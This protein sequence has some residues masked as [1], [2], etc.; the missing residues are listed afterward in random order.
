MQ[1]QRCSNIINIGLIDPSEITSLD[2]TACRGLVEAIVIACGNRVFNVYLCK[3]DTCMY[4]RGICI[5]TIVIAQCIVGAS[6]SY[7]IYYTDC[8][9]INTHYHKMTQSWLINES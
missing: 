9:C 7:I 3:I 8:V 4:I 2:C 1:S 5:L 6:H